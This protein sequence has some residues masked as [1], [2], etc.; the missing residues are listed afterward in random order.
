MSLDTTTGGA[1]EDRAAATPERTDATPDL[2][3]VIPE[4]TDATPDLITVTADRARA[5]D[6]L[7]ALI[8][9]AQAGQPAARVGEFRFGRI[10]LAPMTMTQARDWIVQRAV[11]GTP[12]LVVTSNINHLMLADADPE[13]RAVLQ[14]CE[15]N[16]A[17]GWPLVA[18]S[19]LLGPSLPQRI[20]G[21]DLV[22]DV[23]SASEHLR[24]AILGGPAGSAELLAARV[25]RQHEVVLV[26]PLPADQPLGTD[27]VRR[28]RAA[29][30]MARP[31][32]VLIGLGAPKQELLADALRRSV[33][34][35]IIC[36]G[37]TIEVLSGMRRR[38]PSVVQRVGMEW[39]FRCALEPRRLGGRYVK[40]SSSFLHVLAE[41][42]AS[43]DGG[44]APAEADSAD[45][46]RSA[47]TDRAA[48]PEPSGAAAVIVDRH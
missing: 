38:A 20:A 46:I 34:G 42:R 8:D 28:L 30:A 27:G 33:P 10:S 4:L 36:C 32:L 23:I 24:I 43:R 1:A 17:D 35:P 3:A 44:R 39:A 5:Q 26:D 18:A 2:I 11:D 12:A 40:A 21:I 7:S 31:N 29:L 25:A 16:V 41:E 6:G 14:R 45:P 15:L 47:S 13:F 48:D 9:P 19:R 22:A 37:A